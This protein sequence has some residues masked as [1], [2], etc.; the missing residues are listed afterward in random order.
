M[1]LDN[2]MAAV[3]GPW[4]LT[5]AGRE[6]HLFWTHRLMPLAP[7][8]ALDLAVEGMPARVL[9]D[10]DPTHRTLDLPVAADEIARL[11]AGFQAVVIAG[12]CA[13]MLG[14]AAGLGFPAEPRAFARG[15]ALREARRTFASDSVR[16]G[17]QLRDDED[18]VWLRGDL[19]LATDLGTRVLD[20]A[21]STSPKGRAEVVGTWPLAGRIEVGQTELSLNEL[22]SIDPA[23]VIVVGDHQWDR[24]VAEVRIGDWFCYGAE[25]GEQVLTVVYRREVRRVSEKETGNARG[26]SGD[27]EALTETPLTD[28]DDMPVTVTFDLGEVDVPIGEL[29]R[30][31]EGY[32]FDLHRP[33]DGAVTMRVNGR[34][35]GR[36]E[37]V[38]VEGSLGVRVIDLLAKHDG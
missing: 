12:A 31:D 5:L 38:D 3:R 18:H 11:P 16:L 25:V 10:S 29:Y 30:I 20:L 24:Q 32:T 27:R 23:D 34:I 2:A 33:L 37:L 6:V 35:V 13:D 17:W 26:G 28:V 36:G 22:A 15:S 8:V 1:A 14:R 21:G 19:L 7:L 9:V 4:P